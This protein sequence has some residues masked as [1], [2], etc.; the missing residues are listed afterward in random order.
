MI[1]HRSIRSHLKTNGLHLTVIHSFR[2]VR[3]RLNSILLAR[4]FAVKKLYI[5]SPFRINGRR[6]ITIGENFAAGPGLW[7]EAISHYNDRT[8]NPEVIIGTNVSL[9]HNV[10]IAATTYV[11]IGS[12]VLVGSRVLI[13][14]HNHGSYIGLSSKV[15][16]P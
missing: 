13:T 5:E 12:D 11:E 16:V 7:L 14:D 4:S 9:S 6:S 1:N 3:T 10:H 15:G 8:Y 2:A